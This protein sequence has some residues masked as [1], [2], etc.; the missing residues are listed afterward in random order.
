MRAFVFTDKAL[1][2]Q[3]G[4]FVWLSINTEKRENAAVLAKYPIQASPT[5]FVL[6]PVAEKVVLKYVGGATVTQLQRILDDGARAAG[7]GAD[8]RKPDELLARADAA[9]SAGENKEAAEAFRTALKGMA[10]SSPSYPR[11][12]ESLLFAL[13]ASR[14]YE[15][16]ADVARGAFPHL[17]TSPSAANV[18][19]SGLDCALELDKNLPARPALVSDLTAD[20]ERVLHGP[21]TGLSADDVSGLYQTLAQQRESVNDPAGRTRVLE[22]WAAYLE[23]KA[24]AAKSAEGR[25]AFDAHR[26]TAYLELGQPERGIPMLEASE[27]DFPDDYNPPARLALAYRAMKKYDEALAASDRALER[28]YGPRR[29]VI[30]SARADIYERKGDPAGARKTREDALAWAEALPKEQ[31]SERQIA[32][33]KKQLETSR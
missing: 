14:Q 30:L 27:R 6:D 4:R 15:M 31:V 2:R 7:H 33:L 10:T 22:E 13:S 5:L 1:G 11:T 28:A 26:I 17:R 29:L 12:V 16:C 19:G 25:A 24:A 9:Y 32:A 21:R 23:G 18:A 20:A 3:A 8:D